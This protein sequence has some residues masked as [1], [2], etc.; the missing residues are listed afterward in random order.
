MEIL[1]HRGLIIIVGGP[2]KDNII[3]RKLLREMQVE[4]W[5]PPDEAIIRFSVTNNAV[6]FPL[7]G[8][9]DEH[10]PRLH[11][12]E[13]STVEKFEFPVHLRA[14]YAPPTNAAFFPRHLRN[15][16]GVLRRFLERLKTVVTVFT[17]GD[18]AGAK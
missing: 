7:Q 8:I 2:R 1:D 15:H 9:V 11:A 18:V 5:A 13:I 14:E 12:G 3:V 4:G 6:T 10:R 17:L 16:E